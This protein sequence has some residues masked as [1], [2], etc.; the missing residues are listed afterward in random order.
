M[1]IKFDSDTFYKHLGQLYQSWKD[2]KSSDLWKDADAIAIVY[3]KPDEYRIYRKSSAAQLWLLGYELPDTIIIATEKTLYFITSSR[4]VKLLEQ[5]KQNSSIVSLELLARPKEGARE[6][7]ESILASIEKESFGGKNIGVL[8][9]DKHEGP[10]VEEWEA[11]LGSREL[12][13]VSNGISTLLSVKDSNELK[14][15]RTAATITSAV[16]KSFL[17]PRI[18]NVI[19]NEVKITHTALAQEVEKF[20]LAPEK[21]NVKFSKDMVDK[22]YT[23]I[24]QSGGDYNLKPN[25][26]SNNEHLDFGTIIFSLGVRYRSYCSNIARTIFI[27]PD[28]DQESIFEL[29]IEVQ[30]ECLAN[31]RPERELSSVYNAAVAMI[32]QKRPELLENF[33]NSCGFGMGIEFR[34][35]SLLINAKNKTLIKPGMVFNLSIGFENL[36]LANPGP[37][38]KSPTYSMLLADSVLV[39]EA[40]EPQF[41][42]NYA[43]SLSYALDLD[44]ETTTADILPVQ[45]SNKIILEIAEN[46]ARRKER[47][48]TAA[49]ATKEEEKRRDHQRKLAEKKLEERINKYSNAGAGS[50]DSEIRAPTIQSNLKSYNSPEEFPA[51]TP[52]FKICVDPDRESVILPI[53]GSMVP[54]HVSTIKSVNKDNDYLRINFLYPGS[55]AN[56]SLLNHQALK[57]SKT[58]SFIRELS[59]K[60]PDAN[61]LSQYLVQIKQLAKQVRAREAENNQRRELVQQESLKLTKGGRIPR[62]NNVFP[63]PNVSG[64][65]VGSLEAHR[66]GLRFTASKKLKQPIDIL[67]KNIRYAFFQPADPSEMMVAIHF[68][69]YNAIMVG[70]KKTMDIQFCTE[71]AELSQ[72]LA[73]SRSRDHDAEGLEEERRERAMRQKLNEDYHKFTKNVEDMVGTLEFDIPYRELAF[74]G[75]PNKSFV[76]IQPTVNCLVQLIEPPFFIM[77]LQDIEICNLE[78]VSFGLQQFDA[79][80]VM[81]D[82]SKPVVRIDNVPVK[83]LETLKKWLDSCNINFYEMPGTLNWKRIM[84]TIR[85]DPQGFFEMGGWESML[86]GESDE[87]GAGDDELDPGDEDFES[88]DYQ[89]ADDDDDSLEIDSGAESDEYSEEDE[90]IEVVEEEEEEAPDW[91]ELEEQFRKDDKKKNQKRKMKGEDGFSDD[92]GDEGPPLKK[93][94][95]NSG[96]GS[97]A[98]QPSKVSSRPP[99]RPVSKPSNPPPSRPA[100]RPSSQNVR[101]STPAGRPPARPVAGSKPGAARPP[102]R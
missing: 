80:F 93:S 99:S 95:P 96:S 36:Q 63:R 13:D 48:A 9:K 30:K 58:A 102:K 85:E 68:H 26:C 64:K 91:D 12:V 65:A 42:T 2:N 10:I 52:L 6:Q 19:E 32:Q 70:R 59:F 71:V 51:S 88:D 3:G 18:E 7:L 15:S 55:N 61:A 44:D 37:K 31:L 98:S 72:S 43:K 47:A 77:S 74:Y 14:L 81:T 21:I 45:S 56:M 83:Y 76:L 92:S 54:F 73:P 60:I 94:K 24:I 82:F 69:L 38:T 11:A 1:S 29:L 89:E 16:L 20:I 97:R 41:I 66:N 100:P 34:E 86:K 79:I 46:S 25:A 28:K 78:R 84:K 22:C 90:E 49:D 50:S 75:V 5:L 4:K 57:D 17:I 101:P 27:N 53:Y 8:R 67:Y 33:T 62:L 39:T 23:P 35:F 87:E 40:G